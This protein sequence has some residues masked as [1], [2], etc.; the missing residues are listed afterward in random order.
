MGVAGQ[1]CFSAADAGKVFAGKR[2]GDSFASTNV[3]EGFA[4]LGMMLGKVRLQHHND[5]GG[6]IKLELQNKIKIARIYNIHAFHNP[7]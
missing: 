2:R 3:R 4:A 6:L 1:A 5:A 7:G